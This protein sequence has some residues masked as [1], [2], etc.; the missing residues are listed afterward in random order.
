MNKAAAFTILT[1]IITLV[2]PAR[3]ETNDIPVTAEAVIAEALS[4]IKS[5][6]WSAADVA[7]AIKSVRGLYVRDNATKEGRR[8]WNGNIVSTTVDTNAMTRTTVYE[9]GRTFVDRAEI[10]TLTYRTNDL[11]KTV[12]SNGIPARL[13]AARARRAAE[14]SQ[15]VTNVTVTVTAGETHE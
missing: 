11:Y 9:N 4:V 7:D 12:I 1:T 8:R 14:V 5:E 10:K 13:A 6:G 2:S 15:G 3:S